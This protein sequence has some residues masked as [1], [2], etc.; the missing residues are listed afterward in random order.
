MKLSEITDNS[1]SHIPVLEGIPQIIPIKSVL[2]L[3]SGE[4]STRLFLDKNGPYKD[5]LHLESYEDNPNYAQEIQAL[6][7]IMPHN[8][9]YHADGVAVALQISN[10]NLNDFD[11]CFIDDSSSVESRVKTIKAIVSKFNTDCLIVVHDTDYEQYLSACNAAF[12]NYLMYSICD[13]LPYTTLLY[14]NNSN[15]W[16]RDKCLKL[17]EI[18]T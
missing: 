8:W 13:V 9:V 12:N 17:K 4:I 6:F 7:P 1:S 10:V 11:L 15:T 16:N 2:E 14:K 3:G 18:I 5:L